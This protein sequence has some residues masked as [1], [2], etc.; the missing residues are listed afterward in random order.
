MEEGRE[1]GIDT[2]G[3]DNMHKK[4]RHAALA[5]VTVCVC[6]CVLSDAKSGACNADI[7]VAIPNELW[8]RTTSVRVWP[9]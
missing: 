7:N 1:G 4:R 3:G 6:V 9:R 2:G 8:A 5:V